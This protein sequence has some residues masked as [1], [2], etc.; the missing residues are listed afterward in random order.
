MDNR[1]ID[2]GY[3]FTLEFDLQKLDKTSLPV[4]GAVATW[5]LAESNKAAAP[6]LE[7]AGITPVSEG[8]KTIARVVLSGAETELLTGSQY[9]HQLSVAISGGEPNLFFSGWIQVEDRL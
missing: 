8:G 5:R 4:S 6:L 7:R 9:Y 3:E 2:R 1:A